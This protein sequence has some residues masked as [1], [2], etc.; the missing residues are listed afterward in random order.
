MWRKQ[1]LWKWKWTYLKEEIRQNLD[2]EPLPPLGVRQGECE[3]LVPQPLLRPQETQGLE[4][5]VILKQRPLHPP[6]EPHGEPTVCPSCAGAVGQGNRLPDC[7]GSLWREEQGR[8]R[9]R[10]GTLDASM[11]RPEA[12][13]LGSAQ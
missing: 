4:K 5:M 7:H 1:A 11:P 12:L 10:A 6:G 3:G 2:P 13:C 8:N 9:E